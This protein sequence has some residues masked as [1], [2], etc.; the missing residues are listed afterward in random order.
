MGPAVVTVFVVMMIV[1]ML[2]TVG[3]GVLVLVGAGVDLFV[4]MLV[5]IVKMDVA[6]PE[7]L[8]TQIIEAE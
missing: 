3:L 8:A 6:F 1:N 4:Q 2:V 7:Y 5:G